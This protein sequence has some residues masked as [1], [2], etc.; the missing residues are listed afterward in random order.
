MPGMLRLGSLSK[1]E[2]ELR[3]VCLKLLR[4][5]RKEEVEAEE[6][7]KNAGHTE[8]AKEPDSKKQLVLGELFGYPEV[9][10]IILHPTCRGSNP[11]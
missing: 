6:S 9:S 3:S 10:A 11:T 5:E 2:A 1:S 8:R 4:V 7:I